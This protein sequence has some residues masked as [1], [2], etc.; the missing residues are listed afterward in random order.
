MGCDIH[1][2]T[3]VKIGGTWHCHSAPY[4]DRWYAMF[5]KMAG[6]RGDIENAIS[7]PKGIPDD[8]SVV[9]RAYLEYWKGDGHSHSW[10]AGQEIKDLEMW[11]EAKEKENNPKEHFYPEK[12]WG[13]VLGNGYGD[14]HKHPDPL[15]E[16]VRFV[17][18][19]DN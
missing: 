19:F 8:V 7:P 14:Y 13:Y 18:W 1:F 9:V 4:I 15:I 12:I 10:L 6:V 17:F 3:E 2:F 11:L 5:E 16:D